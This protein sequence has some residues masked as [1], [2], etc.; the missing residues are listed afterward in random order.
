[1]QN[2]NDFELL[3]MIHLN[4]VSAYQ[5]LI[6][7]YENTIR[8]IIYKYQKKKDRRYTQD[9]FFQL[10]RIKLL[11]AVNKYREDKETTFYHFFYEIFEHAM[12][13]YYRTR[14]S[15]KGYYDYMCVSLDCVHTQSYEHYYYEALDMGVS[16]EVSERIIQTKKNLNSIECEIVDLRALGYT[17][18][19][20]S[21]DLNIKKKK[22]DNT[23]H[24]LRKQKE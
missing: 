16:L 9:D 6:K 14:Y 11:L 15:Q 22:I 5:Y 8:Y 4:D 23:L 20:I 24:K 3:Y 12:I 7:K 13:D 21:K 19:Q 10:G 18:L 1:M 2:D 17:Y